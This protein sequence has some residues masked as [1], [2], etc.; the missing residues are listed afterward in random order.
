MAQRWRTTHTVY[1]RK[2]LEPSAGVLAVKT[3]KTTTDWS[4]TQ[5]QNFWSRV[6]RGQRCW[7]WS[8]P[9]NAGGYGQLTVNGV[10]YISSRVAYELHFQKSPGDLFVCHR[11]DKR[12]CCRPEHLFLGTNMDNVTDMIQKGRTC[13]GSDRPNSKL[14]AHQVRVIRSLSWTQKKIAARFGISQSHVSGIKSGTYWSHLG[15]NQ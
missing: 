5:I 9:V 1:R 12:N 15:D 11:C 2:V 3:I 4:E 10:N 14:T 8:G 7:V 13:K 6:K